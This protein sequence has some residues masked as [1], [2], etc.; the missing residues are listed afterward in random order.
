MQAINFNKDTKFKQCVRENI[1]IK[2]FIKMSLYSTLVLNT[3]LVNQVLK[4]FG[5]LRLNGSCCCLC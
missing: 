1:E 5:K 2:P 4:I 3:C